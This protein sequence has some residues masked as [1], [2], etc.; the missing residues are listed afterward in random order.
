MIRRTSTRC[1]NCFVSCDIPRH[2][3]QVLLEVYKEVMVARRFRR[4]VQYIFL[5]LFLDWFVH[6]LPIYRESDLGTD[7][8][9]PTILGSV[10]LAN[11]MV[12]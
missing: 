10:Y 3:L 9:S 2:L 4:T 7:N 6:L 11:G 12:L 5:H 1:H 8:F